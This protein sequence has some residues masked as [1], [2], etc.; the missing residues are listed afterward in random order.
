MCLVVTPSIRKLADRIRQEYPEASNR[1][2]FS[3][4]MCAEW[5]GLY[6]NINSKN[7]NFIPSIKPLVN[8]IEKLRN[9][10]GKSFLFSNKNSNFA[11]SNNNNYDLRSRNRQ[12]LSERF[13]PAELQALSGA[14]EESEALL[15]GGSEGSVPEKQKEVTGDQGLARRQ[16]NLLE[17]WAKEKGIW[18]DNTTTNLNNQYGEPFASE[19]EANVY[20]AQDGKTVVK[21][22]SMAYYIEPHLMLDRIVLHNSLFSDTKMNLTHFGRNSE[23]EFVVIVEQPFV[24]GER[25]TQEE[26]VAFMATLGFKPYNKRNTEFKNDEIGVLI[27]DL[28][29]ENVLKVGKSFFVIDGDFRI[30]TANLGL[31]GTR[32]TKNTF[33]QYEEIPVELMGEIADGETSLNTYDSR[34]SS[35]PD[36]NKK[37]GGKTEVSV[38]E[39][40]NNLITSDTPFKEFVKALRENIGEL[41][42]IRIK[43]VPNS[44]SKVYGIAGIYSTAD[45]TI[46]INRNASFKGKGGKVDNTILHEIVHAIVANSLNTPKHREELGKLF[47]E[48]REKILNK[49]GV[50]SFDTLPENLRKGRLYGL[51]NLDEFAAEFF[52]NSEFISEL[53]DENTFGKRSDKKSLFNRL[54]EWIKSLLPKGVTDT[55]KRSGE[56]LED[57][58]LNSGGTIQADRSLLGGD[59]SAANTQNI[60]LSTSE[61][62]LQVYSDGSDFKDTGKIGYGSVFELSGRQYGISGTEENKEVKKLQQQFPEAKFSNPT[63]EMLAL[64]TTLEYFANRGNGE[65]IVI[66]QDYKGACNYQGLW[67]YSEGSAQRDPKAWKAKEP[68]IKHLVDRS[69]AAIEKIKKDGGSVKINWVKG[70]QTAGTEQARMND[71]ADRYAKSRDNSNTMDDAY[72]QQQQIQQSNLPGPQTKINIYAGTGENA[73]LSNFAERPFEITYEQRDKYPLPGLSADVLWGNKFQS[74]EAAFQAA[75]LA[76]T[77]DTYLTENKDEY[78][79]EWVGLLNQFKNASPKEAKILGKKIKGLDV[80]EWDKESSLIMKTLL[81]ASFEQNPQ[82]LQ[83]LLATGNATLTHTQDRGK[84]GTEFPRL[85]MEVRNEL[86]GNSQQQ[87][88]S[89]I[90]P[91]FKQGVETLAGYY[92]GGGRLI[93]DDFPGVPNKLDDKL[94]NHFM[95]GEELSDDDYRELAKYVSVVQ[96]TDTNTSQSWPY[97]AVS[98]QQ[99]SQSVASKSKIA[100]AVRTHSG[101]WTRQEAQSNPKILYVFTDNTDRDS[102]S[103]II[104]DDSWYSKKYGKGH[105]FPTMT[106]AVVRG[107]DNSMPISTQRWYHQGAKGVTGRWTDAD[108]EEFEKVIRAELQDIVD[109]FNTGKYDTIMF[110]DGDGLFNTSI[111]NITKDRT[112]KLYQALADL[113]HEYGFDSLIPADA[114]SSISS[115]SQ[116]VPTKGEGS[117][118]LASSAAGFGYTPEEFEEI[119]EAAVRREAAANRPKA[120]IQ[121]SGAYETA[122]RPNE[123]RMAQ[124]SRTFSP[125]QIKDR[126]AMIADIFSDILDDAVQDEIDSQLDVVEDEAASEEE[127]TQAR[128]RINALSDPVRG[129]QLA[130]QEKGIPAIMSEIKERIQDYMESADDSKKIL[131]QNTIDYFNDLFNTQA[132]LDIEEREGIR[133]VNLSVAE[134]TVDEDGTDSQDDGDDEVGHIAS[135]SDG[136][137]YRA[138]YEDP[139]ST[140]SK[141]VKSMLYDINRP[142]GEVD[143]LGM[144]KKYPMGRIYASLLSYLSK[145]MENADD[146]LQVDRSF[147]GKD[148]WGND[149]TEES[150]PNGYPTFPVL[151]EMRGMYPWVE[152]II[153]RLTDD[154]LNPEWNSSLRYPSTGGAMASQF[155]VNFRKPYIPYGKVQLG[156]N[157]FGITPL[158]FQMEDK[159][160]KDKLEANYNNRMVLTRHSVYNPDGRVNRENAEWLGKKISEVIFDL[161]H[162]DFVNFPE[163]LEYHNQNPEEE[164]VTQQDIDDYD[165]FLGDVRHILQSFGIDATQDGVAAYL[166]V[167]EGKVIKDMLSGLTYIADRIAKIPDDDIDTFNY[168]VDLRNPYGENVWAHFFD[169]KG[170]IT[171]E[172]YMQ[173][174]Y[175]SASH[176]TKY[177]YSADNYLMKTFR[178][179]SMGSLDDRRAYIDEHYG[180]YEWFRDQETGEWRNSWLE[181]W[182]NYKGDQNEIPYRNIDN[183]TEVSDTGVPKIRQYG[184]WNNDD[185]WQVQNRSYA[186]DSKSNTAFYLAPIFSDSPMSMTVKGPKMNMEELLYGYVDSTNERHQG[187]LVRLVNQ[188]LYRIGLVQKR[189]DAIR[190]GIIKP[191]ANFDDG[192]GLLFCFLPELNSYTFED[193]GESFL[194]RMV[195]LKNE[196]ATMSAI[197]RDQIAAIQ[198]VISGKMSEYAD[199][200]QSNDTKHPVSEEQYYNMVYANASI[201]QLTTVDLAFYGK[202]RRNSDN[203]TL[204]QI[205]ID[206]QKRFKE[207]YAGGNQLNTNSKYGKKTENVIILSDDIIT[208]P[209][210]SD[211]ADA[212][213]ASENLSARDKKD[214]IGSFQDINVADAQAIRSMHSFR[215]ILDMMGKW[216]DRMEGAL[217]HFRN[218]QWNREDY[219]I[220]FQTIKPFVYS[221]IERNDGLG[222]S[223]LVPQQNKNSEI[224]A[225]MMYDLIS[226][227][228]NNSPVYKALSRFMEDTKGADGEPLIDMAQYESAG[229]VGNQGVINISFNPEK[230]VSA[231]D[232]GVVADGKEIELY[233]YEADVNDFLPNDIENAAQNYEAI[234][235]QLDIELE[236]GNLSQ[237]GYQEI[238]QGLRP[239]E[240]EI[241]SMLEQIVLITNPDGTKVINSEVVHTI[242]FDNYYQQQP[243]PEHHID[244]KATFGSQAR[245]IVVADLPDNFNLTV[246]AKD[247]R[248]HTFRGKDEVVDFYYELLNENLIEDFFGKG[249]KKG[250]KGIFA[251]KES[252]RDAVTEIVRGNP[253][254]GKDFAEALQIGDD[255]NFVLSPNSPTVFNLMQ[256]I[257]TS[258]FKNRITKQTINGASLIQAAGIGLDKD[259]RLVFED[260]RLV[261]AECYMPLTSR[262]LFEPLLEKKTVNG[263]E[264]Y[265]LNPDRLKEAG[266]DKAVGYRIPTENK[267]SMLPLIIKGFT[268]LQNGSAIVLPAEITDIAGS[269]FDVDKMF[270]MLSEFYIQNYDMKKALKAYDALEHEDAQEMINALGSANIE[271]LDIDELP[272]PNFREWFELNK[273]DYLLD[274]PVIRRIE[275]DFSK[276][277]KQNGRKARNNMII[278]MMYGILTSKEGTESVLN[279]QGFKDVKRAAKITRIVT[280]SNL[281]VQLQRNTSDAGPAVLPSTEGII[282]EFLNA[283]RQKYPYKYNDA[284]KALRSMS[285]EQIQQMYIQTIASGGSSN[286]VN[287]LLESSTK[288]LE[289]FINTYSAPESPVYPQ[290]FTHSH[291][292]NMAGMNQIGIYA[293]QGSM[294]AKYQR[295][296]VRL[297]EEQQFTVNGN[298]YTDV[299]VSDNGKRLKNVGQMIGASAD[300]G[301]DPN[302]S[303]MGSTSKTAPIIGYMLRTGLSHLEAAL[304][305]NQPHMLMSG[306]SHNKK[307]YWEGILGKMPLA[308]PVRNV[309]TALLI[310]SIMSPLELTAAEDREIAALCYRI[311]MQSDAQEYLTKVSRA[312][313]PNG[314]MQNSYAKARIQRYKV[315]LLQAKMTQPDFPF[316]RISEALSND[317]VDTSASEDTVRE[318]L[319]G[320]PM[321]LLHGMYALGIN[322]FQDLAS[323]YFFGAR[324]W[325]DDRI[326]K[327]ILYNLNE[328]LQDS[329]K[330]AIVNNIYKSYITYKLSGTPLFG[331]E[332]GETMKHKREAYLESFPDDYI[333]VI[334]E[335][336]D[337]RNLIGPVLQ[338]KNFGSRKR[339]VLQDVGSLSKGQKQDVQRRFESLMYSENPE[340]IKLAKKLFIYSFFDNGLQFTNDSFSHLFTTNYLLGFDI[341]TDTLNHLGDEITQEEEEN[342]ISQFLLTYPDAAYK[343]DGIVKEKDIVND[344]IRIDLQNT[345]IR[346]KMVNEL[347]SPDPRAKGINVYPYI[348]H[349]GNIYILDRDMFDRFPGTP[350]YHR[351]NKYSTF[352]RLP[353]FSSQMSV[354]ELAQEFPMGN[355]SSDWDTAGVPETDDPSVEVSMY[356]SFKSMDDSFDFPDPSDFDGPVSQSDKY[357]NEGEGELQKPMC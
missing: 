157:N 126:G 329:E 141:K 203:E 353:L 343:V 170:M 320:Q 357:H 227:G 48:A 333:K 22:I 147:E 129:R 39:I 74:V 97:I 81:K 284:A 272:N 238:M 162:H 251:D 150:Y 212:I 32:T 133:I 330:E 276:T 78:T 4:Q 258:F 148:N 321:G 299:D 279:P 168:M 337:I 237:E 166:T 121:E 28:H 213:N 15:Q 99:A 10:E 111:S 223:M 327:P 182:Y 221:V 253:K 98:K 312:D 318:Q 34:E 290:T 112:P 230:V 140:L 94:N 161:E 92:E 289:K 191:I 195:R 19:G 172:S 159:V 84:W 105:H 3:D 199:E 46:Y 225:L 222:S 186:P 13:S 282:E 31:G 200:N 224:C 106:A 136:W 110:P 297:R 154:Y 257:V 247:N 296:S 347:M 232:N 351:L 102:G 25:P 255:G 17:N 325:F 244:A 220:I 86:R 345:W 270:V 194:E 174:F 181:F 346:K 298:T 6:N 113:L 304:I 239:T 61:S 265:V 311:L 7:P 64:A 335:N 286:A 317:A 266:L 54:V 134:Q 139:F 119:A 306:Y 88:A 40:L 146:F 292:K 142:E 169:G 275:Y 153:Q 355:S 331:S 256:E 118:D 138:R 240:D 43:L 53:N 177:S 263:E 75:K 254:Y 21:E 95:G 285:D 216:D 190:E 175:D 323:P 207:V 249:S 189:A 9:Q 72:P 310:K 308:T 219:D 235:H 160:Q 201:I 338:V 295:A 178:G 49:Y 60:K 66:N 196:K 261:G 69:V 218:N 210:Y 252:L 228:L 85:L 117:N 208:S 332:E 243:T 38:S 165:Q 180:K 185:I 179:V 12:I 120:A 198:D 80:N 52:T 217:E 128:Q 349:N 226:N 152:Q 278:Q 37:F 328:K 205:G 155:Y 309:D 340:A 314:S 124:F 354:T 242:P 41:G 26:I 42:D 45:N 109:E 294:A 71:A 79:D 301:K 96:N 122:L 65:S 176:K 2:G 202:G 245:N 164:T 73:D 36:L 334:Q 82:A 145:H 187:A 171:D 8:F 30:N 236:N 151:E 27:N 339:I 303:D 104:S 283:I 93:T 23:G 55:Y 271:E 131:Y 342:F 63:M 231:I 107:L 125:Q 315:D 143:D 70:H 215:S 234:K 57:I 59:S 209:S 326:V 135:G 67:D 229:K 29:D 277:P 137:S 214:I 5:I 1:N 87:P 116:A 305:I 336:E 269:D 90:E 268:P 101:Y 11:Q 341:Y 91:R 307:K 16:E 316:M 50:D 291:A 123:S 259:L 163:L 58:L 184:M 18:I 188:E 35:D 350:I 281:R 100:N 197:E 192:C 68:Y 158:N 103:G 262:K 260:G 89:T 76:Y 115:P 193:T 173:S 24:G 274:T 352:P 246:S 233:T 273:E 344:T 51:Q 33:A 356:E 56:I 62:P 300:N 313:S 324:K 108:V 156:D 14:L 241:V 287:I 264:V 83:R 348:S 293:I 77:G 20:L 206:F 322:S 267:S 204:H 248:K 144:Q 149:I 44:N 319:K 250:L 127:K 130:A 280:D 302:L 211:V 47:D 114:Q 288:D 183:V 132:T 167:D